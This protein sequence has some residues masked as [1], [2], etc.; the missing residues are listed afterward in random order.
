MP[1]HEFVL[2]TAVFPR[3]RAAS[4]PL[5]LVWH[6]A[7]P[8]SRRRSYF[9]YGEPPYKG[10]TM[11]AEKT[12]SMSFRVSPRLKAMLEVAAARENRSLTNMLETLILAHCEQ[13]RLTAPA[14]KVNRRRGARK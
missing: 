9:V 6:Y 3:A 14:P 4:G 7:R 5:Q 10:L 12:I 8:R 2:K 13:H 1:Q 11:T